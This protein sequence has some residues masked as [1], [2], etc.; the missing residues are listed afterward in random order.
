M[1]VEVSAITWGKGDGVSHPIHIHP[2]ACQARN[3]EHDAPYW[4]G[5]I[6]INLN[7]LT[8]RA[9]EHY[10]KHPGPHQKRAA[11]LAQRLRSNLIKNVFQ[12]YQKT[13]YVWEQVGVGHGVAEDAWF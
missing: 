1:G 4:R 8:V 7:Y 10:A 11:D 5:P 13:G 2:V 12:Q 3:T 6:W 9:L